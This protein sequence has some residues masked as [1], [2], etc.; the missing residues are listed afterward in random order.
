MVEVEQAMEDEDDF[1]Q[2]SS[3]PF[4][5]DDKISFL[6][7]NEWSGF[8]QMKCVA[9]IYLFFIFIWEKLVM[10]ECANVNKGRKKKEKKNIKEII[11]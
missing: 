10:C 1:S 6:L 11:F 7:E 3:S 9:F 8:V 2:P 5:F 4:P